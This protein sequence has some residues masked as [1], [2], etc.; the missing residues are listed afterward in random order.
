[1]EEFKKG[2][3]LVSHQS[4][5]IYIFEEYDNDGKLMVKSP[6]Q[7]QPM[8]SRHIHFRLAN[9]EEKAKYITMKLLGDEKNWKT[10][11]GKI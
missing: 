8:Y 4:G 11:Y 10:Y 1:M 2:D 9:E 7:T 6:F 5:L 3:L